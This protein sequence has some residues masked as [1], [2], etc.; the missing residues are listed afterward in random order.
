[1]TPA[2]Q[3]QRIASIVPTAHLNETIDDQYF[4]ALDHLCDDDVYMSFFK[5]RIAEGK[6]VILD[7]STVELGEPVDPEVYLVDAKLMGASQVLCPDWLYEADRTIES[8]RDFVKRAKRMHYKGS[9]MGAPQGK[10]DNEWLDCARRMLEMPEITCLGVS[11]RYTNFWSQRR[12]SAVQG[13]RQC[14]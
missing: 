4:M 8:S 2:S 11:R 5:A 6:F 10:D 9:I 13:L 14:R 7:N 1:M 12:L 3:L